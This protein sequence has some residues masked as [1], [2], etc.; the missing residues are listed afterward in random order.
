MKIK[1][2]YKKLVFI[3]HLWPLQPSASLTEK[4]PSPHLRENYLYLWLDLGEPDVEL[5]LVVERPQP[6]LVVRD[7]GELKE[8]PAG[9]Q[10]N[11]HFFP[12]RIRPP[13]TWPKSC[14]EF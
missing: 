10:F 14:L 2:T 9:V 12:P 3:S 1:C 11:R 6:L 7:L 8:E 5:L 4:N 13:R